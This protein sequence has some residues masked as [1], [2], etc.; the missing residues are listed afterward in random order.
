MT[1][2]D[3]DEM[4]WDASIVPLE[5]ESTPPLA[6]K[7]RYQLQSI[8]IEN[9]KS[10]KGVFDI[11]PFPSC[12]ICI[13]GPNGSGK[14]NLMD[15]VAF[16][17][18]CA[19]SKKLRGD[20]VAANLI[21]DGGDS[22]SVTV[23]VT[24][25]DETTSFCRQI[26]ASRN[27]SKYLV[28]GRKV[29][30]EAFRQSM[31]ECG[32]DVKG[33]FLVFQGDVE[34]LALSD[35]AS[36][37]Q[38][39][40]RV[41]G[42]SELAK[43]FAS[44]KADKS[45]LEKEYAVF[46]QRKKK[47]VSEKK[48]L[49]NEISEIEK[50]D[51]IIA[52]KSKLINE[53]FLNKLFLADLQGTEESNPSS[54][55]SRSIAEIGKDI[56]SVEAALEKSKAARAKTEMKLSKAG[57]KLVTEEASCRAVSG[58]VQVVEAKVAQS[59][60]QLERF[61]LKTQQVNEHSNSMKEKI[62]GIENQ[63][64]DQNRNLENEQTALERL[65]TSG[66]VDIDSQR[67]NDIVFPLLCQSGI[68]RE[69]IHRLLSKF[70]S[71]ELPVKL[72]ELKDHLASIEAET[73]RTEESIKLLHN[74]RA[75]VHSQLVKNEQ[76]ERLV[77]D[78]IAELQKTLE[79][80]TRETKKLGKDLGSAN[81]KSNR[82][83]NRKEKLE[84]EKRSLLDELSDM[85]ENEAEIA[86]ERV[87]RE[88]LLELI[89][90]LGKGNIF[91]RFV[92][93]VQLVDNRFSVAVQTAAGRYCD[94]VLVKNLSV[95]KEAVNWLKNERKG[96]SLT[97]VPV[98]DVRSH[99]DGSADEFGS[100]RRAI[101][102]VLPPPPEIQR[103]V[104]FILSKSLICE[105]MSEA[106]SV[107]YSPHVRG[108]G[109]M[110]VVTL[111]GDKVNANGTITVGSTA[112]AGRFGLR[113]VNEISAKLELIEKELA[114]VVAETKSEQSELE[115]ISSL[116]RSKELE[117]AYDEARLGQLKIEFNRLSDSIASI[118]KFLEENDREVGEATAKRQTVIN[119]LDQKRFEIKSF[120][121][122]SSR[123]FLANIF[124]L[125]TVDD[126][127]VLLAVG[128]SVND[129]MMDTKSQLEQSKKKQR[130][131]VAQIQSCVSA[132]ENEHRCLELELKE[133]GDA[134]K[135]LDQ[136]AIVGRKTLAA[137]EKE[138]TASQRELVKVEE[139]VKKIGDESSDLRE[140]KTKIESEIRRLVD[141]MTVL[142]REHV[143]AKSEASKTE[144]R[145]EGIKNF[146]VQILKEAVMKNA[147][148]PL[149][150]NADDLE[151]GTREEVSKQIVEQVFVSL[152]AV[153][154]FDS[155]PSGDD[156]VESLIDEVLSKIDLSTVSQDIKKRGSIGA[157]SRQGAGRITMLL[158]DL[159]RE[160]SNTLSQ[161]E[162]DLEQA[163]AGVSRA[164]RNGQ[165]SKQALEG[166][167]AEL[168]T[169]VQLGEEAK[170]KL[171]TVSTELGRVIEERNKRFLECF[172][173]VSKKVD[174]LYKIL[175]SYD[176]T[177]PNGDENM[178]TT[179]V[180]STA[181][182]TLDLENPVLTGS[183][184]KSV[185]VF[186]SG[187]IF[188]LMPPF[189]R[190]TNIELL[191]GGEKTVAAVALL[192]AL[193]A[194]SAPPF[195]M[196]DEIDAALDSENVGVLSR[197][198]KHAVPHQLLVISLKESLYAK[199]DCLI[200]VYKD[201]TTTGSGL[202]T[203]DLRPYSEEEEI[204]GNLET[205]DTKINRPLMTPGGVVTERRASRALIGGA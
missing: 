182:A 136:E 21:A 101:D 19:D 200:G 121:I 7:A 43:T 203:L 105:S 66:V 74:R 76:S 134:L 138:L 190:Y 5:N 109:G 172:S 69:D 128:G 64:S 120:V 41:S 54:V 77:S 87:I 93:L 100:I 170:Q 14:S 198:M 56:Q 158:A 65:S 202:I 70:R 106:R 52:Q 132:L 118:G 2:Q 15:A 104:D 79:I 126:E 119:L 95:A 145:L 67:D 39:I 122:Q 174:E 63:I 25:D 196:V 151:M 124:G 147:Y 6:L 102:C 31:I 180:V 75:E 18:N 33:N 177:I 107:A 86:K 188:S 62:L 168:G 142:R 156:S 94:A 154:P 46:A 141:Q 84:S 28:N 98:D 181:A 99:R 24:S 34:A 13:V 191:S 143:E 53:F 27:E 23:T 205:T 42:S 68:S 173:F 176:Q 184:L 78:R 165:D 1:E 185:E 133:C 137:L 17:F 71:L 187:L 108:V 35:P 192:F 117:I 113:Q 83:A 204:E 82:L 111:T 160:F 60:Q 40:D 47:L 110:T 159:E 50:I 146:K 171:S 129:P 90:K 189:K 26:S 148:I 123:I 162:A 12:M 183:D 48:L 37:G 167:E 116:I 155:P 55:T 30:L 193:L 9:F 45:E 3:D 150:L 178:T 163:G 96:T 144:K 164:T 194:F 61:E 103:G 36:L 197:F 11:G 89:S 73:G 38:T 16:C 199:S 44:L 32:L 186:N 135:Q 58:R 175:T 125:S 153:V 195:S 85:K 169:L 152:S 59:L 72:G 127:S 92:D 112:A 57:R 49:K 29:S 4:V 20:G 8:R 149:R 131:T 115:R 179:V 10:Y 80:N 161:I 130:E 157:A 140:D 201:L 91:G 22:A 139:C 51:K 81:A 166:I 97:F 114:I 88:T